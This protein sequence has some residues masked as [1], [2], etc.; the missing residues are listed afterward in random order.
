MYARKYFPNNIILIINIYI[1]S[2][3]NFSPIILCQALC[4]YYQQ[5]LY[6]IGESLK[7]SRRMWITCTDLGEKVYRFSCWWFFWSF[8]FLWKESRFAEISVDELAFLNWLITTYCNAPYLFLR[9]TNSVGFQIYSNPQWYLYFVICFYVHKVPSW[10]L[11][12]GKNWPNLLIL[13]LFDIPPKS[14]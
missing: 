9:N 6:V 11:I 12:F 2:S 4:Y 14:L 10:D 8:P 13:W 1:N 5:S 7:Y 3:I